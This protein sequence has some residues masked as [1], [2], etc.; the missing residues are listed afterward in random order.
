[1]VL[2]DYTMSDRLVQIQNWGCFT[3]TYRWY[4]PTL[5]LDRLRLPLHHRPYRPSSNITFVNVNFDRTTLSTLVAALATLIWLNQPISIC[6]APE[7]ELQRRR[8]AVNTV[9][10]LGAFTL[11]RVLLLKSLLGP[12]TVTVIRHAID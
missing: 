3:Y 5:S 6:P 8:R 2:D 11:Q 9:N 7:S 10:T 1:M 12:L 4:Q